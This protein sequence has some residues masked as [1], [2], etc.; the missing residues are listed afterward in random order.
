VKAIRWAVCSLWV[1]AG[2]CRTAPPAGAPSPEAA[3]R[4]LADFIAAAEVGDFSRVYHLLSGEWRARY[5]PR[6]LE[7]DFA[8]EPLARERLER[9]RGALSRGARVD[10]EVAEFPIGDGRAVRLVREHGDF[11]VVALE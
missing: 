6:R 9:A 1:L 3:S 2:G 10:G 7:Q 5:T 8:D 4:V 11:R